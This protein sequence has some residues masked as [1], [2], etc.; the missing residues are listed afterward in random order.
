MS[1]IIAFTIFLLYYAQSGCIIV[2]S[3][4]H[5]ENDEAK[6]G[7]ATEMFYLRHLTCFSNDSKLQISP[8]VVCLLASK[9]WVSISCNIKRSHQAF[10]SILWNKNCK[11]CQ[12]VSYRVSQKF[13]DL[14]RRTSINPQ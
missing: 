1:K 6:S 4:Y 11:L 13:I 12:Y 7:Q 3:S 10:A 8:L 14:I 5:L 9:Q 2:L